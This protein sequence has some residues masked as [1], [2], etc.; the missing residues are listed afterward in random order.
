MIATTM[1][2]GK[3]YSNAIVLYIFCGVIIYYSAAVLDWSSLK[4]SKTDD[5]VQK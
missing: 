4:D 5:T 3:S 1:V 2:F